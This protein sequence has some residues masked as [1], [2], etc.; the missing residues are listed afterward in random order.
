MAL[1][2][3]LSQGLKVDRVNKDTLRIYRGHCTSSHRDVPPLGVDLSWTGDSIINVALGYTDIDITASGAGGLDTGSPV[4]GTAYFVW[5][6]KNPF[7]GAM[8]AFL[9]AGSS[10]TTVTPPVSMYAPDGSIFLRPLPHGQVWKNSTLGFQPFHSSGGECPIV[11]FTDSEDD[12]EYQLLFEGTS[13]SWAGVDCTGFLA[14]ATDRE[15]EIFTVTQQNIPN[16]GAGE[17]RVRT[18]STQTKGFPVGYAANGTPK[19]FEYLRLRTDSSGFIE[20]KVTGNVKLSIY[21]KGKRR[22][23]SV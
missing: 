10:Y 1:Q 4:A 6:A 12:S 22:T 8:C 17:A 3:C 2:Q 7:T 13:T 5:L 14:D 19:I 16:G 23:Q 21:A 9:S 15:I 20:Y 18:Y 11:D